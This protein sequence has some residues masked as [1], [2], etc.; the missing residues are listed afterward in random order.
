MPSNRVLGRSL[1]ARAVREC[2]ASY[3]RALELYDEPSSAMLAVEM[4]MDDLGIK[5]EALRIQVRHAVNT[6]KRA[7]VGPKRPDNAPEG[8]WDEFLADIGCGE[9]R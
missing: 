5:D 6:C 3:A 2:R 4:T 9:D 8:F 1:A 7:S